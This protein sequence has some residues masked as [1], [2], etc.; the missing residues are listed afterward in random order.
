MEAF[1]E[2]FQSMVWRAFFSKF[3]LR[4]M[5]NQ[6]DFIWENPSDQLLRLCSGDAGTIQ[7]GHHELEEMIEDEHMWAYRICIDEKCGNCATHGFPCTNLAWHG[8]QNMRLDCLW[9]PNWV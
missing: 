1:P 4:D 8:F 2:N 7:Q 9:K 6:L 3:V 5:V